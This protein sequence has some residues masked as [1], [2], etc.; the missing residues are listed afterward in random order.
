MKRVERWVVG[1][2]TIIRMG[3]AVSPWRPRS[4]GPN[5]LEVERIV[6]DLLL[7]KGGVQ[8][9][10]KARCIVPLGPILSRIS[11]A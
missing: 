3:R 8:T 5:M 7:E 10:E 11:I 2:A 1:P 6:N 9:G 4:R